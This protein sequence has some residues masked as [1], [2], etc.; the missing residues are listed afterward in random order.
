MS[1]QLSTIMSYR[2][3]ICHTFS[4]PLMLCDVCSMVLHPNEFCVATGQ[5]SGAS[6]QETA[7][8]IRVWDARSLVT[9]AILG[10]GTFQVA[11]GCLAFSVEVSI[12]SA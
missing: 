10:L 1:G 3:V 6:G 12:Y 7:A 9:Y 4:A 8:H 11:V 2:H 5:A